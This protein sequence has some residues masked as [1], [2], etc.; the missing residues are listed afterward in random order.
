MKGLRFL[1]GLAL[2]PLCAAAAQTVVGLLRTLAPAS[3]A[4]V[5]AAAW[6]LGG[7]F[8]LWLILYFTLPAP[9]RTYVL[10]HELTHAL[11]GSAMGARVLNLTVSKDGGSVTLTK[12]NF[13]VTLAPYFFPLYTALVIAGY[14]SLS[15][16]YDLR[17]YE[18]LWLGLVGFTWAFHFTFT[19]STLLERQS[20]IRECGHL[21]SYAVIV[22]MN[23]LGIGLWVVL[24]SS[25][26]L[27]QMVALLGER[28]RGDYRWAWHLAADGLRRLAAGV[29]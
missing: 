5:P 16:F 13:L 24:L 14:Y 7:G 10:A 21:F 11:W 22:L 6:A 9:M 19:C 20:D 8:A 3:S 25:A 29:Q 23:V 15:I 18:P 26:T 12:S 1:V 4:V 27:E 17:R 28:A 2:L